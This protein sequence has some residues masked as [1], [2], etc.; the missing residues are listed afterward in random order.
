MTTAIA[1]FS[2]GLDSI[3]ASRLILRQGIRLIAVKFVTP[4]FHYDQLLSPDYARQVYQDYGIEVRLVDISA[5]YFAMLRAPAHGYGKH[6]NPCLD[7]KILM[8]TKAREMM[9]SLGASF[10][11]SG[12][13][14]G[15]RPMS[16]RRDAL[17]VVE[18]DAGCDGILLRPLCAKHLKPTRPELCGEVDR[19]RLGDFSGRGRSL[20]IALAREMG[21]ADY[22]TP[23]GGCVLTDTN[24]SARIRRYYAGHQTIRLEDMRLLVI[25]RHLDLPGGGWL[26][27]GRGEA[28]NERV[29]ALAE[30]G[31]IILRLVDRPG[32]TALLRNL[33][34]ETDLSVAAGLVAR[35]GKK[36]PDGRPLPGEVACQGPTGTVVILGEPGAGAPSPG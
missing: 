8:M 3:L 18:R 9:A 33:K 15:Q 19:E 26:A 30:P 2:G 14:L 6:F 1:L 7:C 22:P 24:V 34:Q 32:P 4:F 25:G 35:Y 10:L 17:R 21:V 36:G 12:E 20:Q 11:I 5:E 16:Q 13:V 23:S 29:L 31:D 27:M 28:E